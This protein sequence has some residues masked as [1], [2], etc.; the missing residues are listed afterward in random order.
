MATKDILVFGQQDNG[1]P[2]RVAAELASGAPGLARELG[3][4][5][6]GMTMGRGAREAAEALG[7]YGLAQVYYAPDEALSDY[8]VHAQAHALTE[9][10]RRAD[11]AAVLLPATNDGRDVAACL[12][13]I[14]DTGILC[15]ATRL[16]VDADEGKIV[17]EQ[18]AFDGALLVSCLTNDD[19]P[20]IITVRGKVF[21]A[22]RQPGAQ[23][24]L[25]EFSYTPEPEAQTVRVLEVVKNEQGGE[26]RP[27]EGANI[28]VSGGR[29]LG[30]PEGFGPLRELADA[31]GAAVGASRAAVDA[32]WAPYTM[33]VGQTGKTVKPKAYIA[34]GIS[35][36]IQHKVGMQGADTIIAINKDPD[37]PIF[38][39][40][41][42][43]IVGDLNVIVPRLIEEIQK[44][45]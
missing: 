44:R 3:G 34:V 19:K 6:I 8:G 31:L 5:A 4:R 1:V 28:V 29:G 26:E 38:T 30:G 7:P 15:N 40:A 22:E 18:G 9:A 33:Q 13:A 12:A 27:L 45:K 2:N 17:S 39:F 10:V 16:Y 24:T 35:G 32:G 36:A 41:D 14:L 21:A 42:L 43:G 25:E 11:P 37:A 20:E 23:A